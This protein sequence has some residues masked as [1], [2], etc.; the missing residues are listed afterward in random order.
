MLRETLEIKL[1]AFIGFG[2]DQLYDFLVLHN[3]WAK[4]FFDDVS[5][6]ILLYYMSYNVIRKYQ[7]IQVFSTHVECLSF[8]IQFSKSCSNVAVNS[9]GEIVSPSLILFFN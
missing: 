8:P 1:G 6:W 7:M 5:L 9:L 3:W 4:K 2:K